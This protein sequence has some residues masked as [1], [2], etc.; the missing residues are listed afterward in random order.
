VVSLAA[1][2]AGLGAGSALLAAAETVA[3]AAG[4][5]RL[6]LAITNDNL[7]ALRFCQRRGLSIVAVDA[8]AVDRARELKPRIPR[9][10]ADGIPLHDELRLER[11][12]LPVQASLASAAS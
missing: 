9:I 4:A 2:S 12:P 5:A 6:W 7:S 10:G 1:T 11:R 3:L 8:G